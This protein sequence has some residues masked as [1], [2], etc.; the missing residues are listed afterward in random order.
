MAKAATSAPTAARARDRAGAQDGS[1][2]QVFRLDEAGITVSEEPVA[3][4]DDLMPVAEITRATAPS[5]RG[6]GLGTVF[7]SALGGLVSLGIGLALSRLI[8][9]LAARAEW[10]GFVGLTLAGLFAAAALAIA[11]R[12]VYALARLSSLDAIRARAVSAIAEDDRP[13]AE[14]VARDLLALAGRIPSLARPRAE[15]AGHLSAI[16][17]GADLVRLTERTLM[18]PLDARARQMVS[19]A[20]KRVSVVTAVSPRAAVDLIFVFYTA[21]ALMRRLSQLYGGRPGTLGT[22][23]LVRHVLAHLAITGGMAAGD[24]LVQQVLGHGIAARLSA[25]L[26]EGVV[27]GL[28]TARLGLAAIAVTRPLPFAALPAPRLSDVAAGLLRAA[29]EDEDALQPGSRRSGKLAKE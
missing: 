6:I 28:L 26:G 14:H 7:W 24:S 10:L 9:D 27:N 2:P 13:K 20:A 3:A 1:R 4:R 8:E 21:L 29:A 11:A 17:D 22:V 18:T 5:G 15:L 25:R 12:E 19:D 16:I 23:R